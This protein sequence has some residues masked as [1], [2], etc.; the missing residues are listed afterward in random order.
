MVQRLTVSTDREGGQ[1][2]ESTAPRVFER[3]TFWTVFV[4][5][6]LIL[7]FAFLLAQV[8]RPRHGGNFVLDY[9]CWSSSLVL[10]LV[11]VLLA[12]R[13]RKNANGSGQKIGSLVELI[14][15]GAAWFEM[16]FALYGIISIAT[17]H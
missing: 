4:L 9:T 16:A 14:V 12:R 15:T 6:T 5:G 8:P 11:C 1:M 13:I 2:T 10:M 17:G 3:A 7:V